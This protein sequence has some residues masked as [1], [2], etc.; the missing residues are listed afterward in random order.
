[1]LYFVGKKDLYNMKKIT[2]PAEK[3]EAVYYSDFSGKCFGEYHPPVEMTLEFNYGSKYDGSKITF[4]LDDKD[5]DDILSMLK[6][7]LINESKKPLKERYVELNN[8]YDD[9]VQTRDWSSCDIICNQKEFLERL[10]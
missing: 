4:H 2:K 8:N 7:K 1:M 6:G 9:S 3:E 5:V 10:I